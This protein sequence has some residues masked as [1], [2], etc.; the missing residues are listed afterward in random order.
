MSPKSKKVL[1][2][3]SAIFIILIIFLIT[4]T[5]RYYLD[6]KQTLIVKIAS[7]ATSSIGQKVTI[8]NLSFSPSAGINLYNI[9]IENPED[10][11]PGK[12]L[13]IKRLYLNMRFS[14]LFGGRFYFKKITVYSPE[15]T[16]TR[17]KNG[18]LNV[19]ERLI[20]FFKKEPT[21]K[22]Q[23]DEFDV[24]SGIFDFNGDERFRN[25]KINLSLKNLSS[26]RGAETLISGSSLYAGDNR[27]K[28]Q[29]RVGLKEKPKR[30]NV[31][32]LTDD[33][34][35]SAL[36]RIFYGRKM[37]T[38]KAKVKMGL[39]MEGDT[40]SGINFKSLCQVKDAGYPLLQ[41][42]M[43]DFR[44]NSDA[45]MNIRENSILVKELSLNSGGVLSIRSK[46]FITNLKEE[47]AYNAELKIDRLDLSIFDIKKDL[48][49]SGLLTSDNINIKG[50]LGRTLPEISGDIFVKGG[51]LKVENRRSV[52]KDAFLKWRIK[53]KGGDLAFKA[54]VQAGKI[55]ANISGTIKRVIEKDRSVEMKV[56]L[57][58]VKVPDIR[59]SFWDVFPDGLLYARMDGSISSNL[60]VDYGYG[61]LKV[62]GESRFK[63]I[64][65][66]G[67]N[68]EYSVGPINGILPIRYY[69]T[70]DKT[71]I[72]IPFFERNRLDE[73]IGYYS[74]EKREVGYSK[75]TIGSLS[76]GF[77]FLT[78]INIWIKQEGAVLNIGRV[79]GNIFGGR[80]NGSAVLDISKG[81]NYRAGMLLKGLSLTKLCDGIEPIKGYISGK[82]NGIANLK[83]S[84]TGV[85]QLMG[86]ADFW[87]YSTNDEKT[88]ISGTFLQKI[89]GPSL[90]TY[91]GDR[92]FDKGVLSLYLKDGFVIFKELEISNKN[93]F[94]ITDLSLKVAPLNNRI[95]IDHLMWTI[96]EAAA[97]AKEKRY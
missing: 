2:I 19:S 67:E 18:R 73:L 93:F 87:T 32:I 28:I 50:K 96:T 53:S 89:G 5:Y 97:R 58:D 94:G 41:K 43:K 20:S 70:P 80:L 49:V 8:G 84:G 39:Q 61:G 12:L 22:Y 16:L 72:E 91:L 55:S 3:T 59:D 7:A 54:D 24:D 81:M 17:D 4:L 48:A 71:E 52:L 38:E 78:D 60:T 13:E 27:I 9:S 15:V 11:G 65:L 69:R 74:G 64:I 76:Y 44:L 31:S 23:I 82:V 14:E 85:S 51:A 77:K 33:I 10:F 40:E 90:R 37:S 25:D 79:S 36:E 30:F 83:G 35:L 88:K 46:A 68:N 26:N 42:E 34:P 63:N 21:I 92:R 29:G 62:N 66:G 95:A 75:I 1:K 57:P 6:L 56:V 47:P 45:F 86:N